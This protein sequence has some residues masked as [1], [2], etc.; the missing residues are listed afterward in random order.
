[1]AKGVKWRSEYDLRVQGE[2]NSL[3][4]IHFASVSQSTGENW[5]H[6]LLPLLFFFFLFI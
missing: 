3:D 6:V 5:D 2:E 1:M 4:L